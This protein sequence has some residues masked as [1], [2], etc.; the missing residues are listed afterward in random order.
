MSLAEKHNWN[1]SAP[2]LFSQMARAWIAGQ[3]LPVQ[4]Q[5]MK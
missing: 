3:S 1:L 2:G 4:L 5:A